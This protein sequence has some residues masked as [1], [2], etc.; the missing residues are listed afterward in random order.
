[1]ILR[2]ATAAIAVIFALTTPV[3]AELEV[4]VFEADVTPTPG[5]PLGGASVPPSRGVESPLSA[6][7]IILYPEGQDPIVMCAVDWI[8]IAN[9]GYDQW[10][11]ALADAAE[12]VADRVAV[13][14]LHQHD[15]P[16]YDPDTEALLAAADL[17]RQ[18]Y[19]PKACAAA[20]ANTVEA[21]R[22]AAAARHPVTHVGH[23]KA[24]VEK[25]ASNRRILGE[26]GKVK[27]VRYTATADPEI[28][29]FPEGVIDPWIR[30]LSFWDSDKTIAIITYYATHPQ[31]FY[32]TG[33][34]SS[35]FPGM[36]RTAREAALP[37]AAHIHFNGAGGNIGA[38]KYND[39][40]PENRPVLARRLEDGMRE[41]FENTE[42]LSV[43]GMD[44]AWRLEPLRLPLSEHINLD[45]ERAVLAD[46]NASNGDKIR[47]ARSVAFGQRLE[48]TAIPLSCLRLGPIRLLHLPGELFVEYQLMA[49]E[50]APDHFVCMA[51]YG[52]YGPG[53]IGT[54]ISYDQGGYETQPYVSKT[55]PA[56]EEVLRE[57]LKRILAE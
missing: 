36:A 22:E 13:H 20:L 28:R 4:A 16:F 47:A 48:E 51:A 1:M 21:V 35:D 15:A 27:H 10:R 5:S 9:G 44:V 55:S 42:R 39:G 8:G 30:A 12:T 6:R 33:L 46:P 52:D 50:L 56:V 34:V 37:E 31:S 23:G 26:D 3:V 45:S 25:V 53:Y 49:Q 19:N 29:A 14:V 24:K 38:G 11:R 17:P 41:S 54:E 18:I 43:A 40:S 57:G 7:G 32:R 2:I